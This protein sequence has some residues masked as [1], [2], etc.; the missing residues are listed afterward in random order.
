[1]FGTTTF[2][3]WLMEMSFTCMRP[4]NA[5]IH[6]L[7]FHGTLRFLTNS[8]CLTHHCLFYVI[9]G[10]SYIGIFFFTRLFLDWTS[11]YFGFLHSQG[12]S[13]GY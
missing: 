7:V 4:L 1:M 9:V 3:C 8:I 11:S 2:M 13:G 10:W 12:I 5:Y 6:W